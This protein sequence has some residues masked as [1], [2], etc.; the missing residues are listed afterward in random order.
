MI[1]CEGM[2]NTKRTLE[3]ETKLA[4]V[5]SAVSDLTIFSTTNN[6]DR[7]FEDFFKYL[8][9]MKKK[10][11]DKNLFNKTLMILVRDLANHSM[12]NAI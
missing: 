9:S 6:F 10:L 8:V 5:C 3:E 7:V 12:E 2:F 4:L 1:D 11:K